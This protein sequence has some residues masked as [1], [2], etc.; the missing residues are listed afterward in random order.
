MSFGLRF[1]F[2]IRRAAIRARSAPL[3]A[4]R[5]ALYAAYGMRRLVSAWPG[6]LVTVRR[7]SDNATLDVYAAGDGWLNTVALL[8]WCGSASAYVTRWWDQSGLGRHAEQASSAAQPVLVSAGVLV[9]IGGKPALLSGDGMSLLLNLTFQSLPVSFFAS[10]KPTDLT[11]TTYRRIASAYSGS[12][13]NLILDFRLATNG[14]FEVSFNN[15]SYVN[16][17]TTISNTSGNIISILAD[18]SSAEVRANGISTSGASGV[19]TSGS[20]IMMFN[21]AAI[22]RPLLS[23]IGEFILLSRRLT[24]PEAVALERALGMPRGVILP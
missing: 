5:A 7:S 10:I 20:Q 9:T 16:N 22:A 15:S 21:Y 4:F 14:R 24:A 13:S 6:P 8:A 23:N 12:V 2:G 11:A 18:A 1:G 19:A 3:D 17:S